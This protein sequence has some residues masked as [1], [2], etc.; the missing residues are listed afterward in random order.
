MK[1]GEKIGGKVVAGDDHFVSPTQL[2]PSGHY[3]DALSRSAGQSDF[4]PV[5]ADNRSQM[6]SNTLRKGEIFSRIH[7]F[8]MAFLINGP[9]RTRHGCERKNALV[10]AVQISRLAKVGEM[11]SVAGHSL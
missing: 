6:T 4:V 8:R 3:T 2:Q 7:A 1:P 11:R 10:G 9:A 5:A